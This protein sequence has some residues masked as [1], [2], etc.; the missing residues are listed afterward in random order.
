MSQG[1]ICSGGTLQHADFMRA[2]EYTLMEAVR[3]C[4]HKTVKRSNMNIW[5]MYWIIFSRFM[6]SFIFPPINRSNRSGP[7]HKISMQQNTETIWT[8]LKLILLPPNVMN[9]THKLKQTKQMLLGRFYGSVL[10][11]FPGHCEQVLK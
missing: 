5:L 3:I 11:V 4:R 9:F 1:N 6:D 8:I 2:T 7:S 10:S